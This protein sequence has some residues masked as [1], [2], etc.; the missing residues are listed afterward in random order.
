MTSKPI[1]LKEFQL[2]DALN[3]ESTRV[4]RV[5]S[6]N[7]RVGLFERELADSN[8]YEMRKEDDTDF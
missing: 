6:L 5:T 4:A 8:A 2:F 1:K 3:L 7:Y